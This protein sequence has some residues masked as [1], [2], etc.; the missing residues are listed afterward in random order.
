[1]NHKTLEIRKKNIKKKRKMM[2]IYKNKKVGAM[3]L[4]LSLSLARTYKSHAEFID[5][6]KKREMDI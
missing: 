1:M 2:K 3:A 4:S 6:K 5:R